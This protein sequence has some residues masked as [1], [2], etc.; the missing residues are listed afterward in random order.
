MFYQTI[1][2]L[3]VVTTKNNMSKQNQ[4]V[5][6]NRC[7]LDYFEKTF[8]ET[9]G[10]LLDCGKAIRRTQNNIFVKSCKSSA[11]KV[12]AKKK[13]E[14]LYNVFEAGCAS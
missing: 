13:T 7:K 10:N 5:S 14:K 2:R 11:E 9:S 12:L 6:A 1:F 8:V 3:I 4:D